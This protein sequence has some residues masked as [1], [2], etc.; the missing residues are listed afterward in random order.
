MQYVFM[1]VCMY[2]FP[3][4]MMAGAFELLNIIIV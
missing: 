2:I 1:Y 4:R 3:R